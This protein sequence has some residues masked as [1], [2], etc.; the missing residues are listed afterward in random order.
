MSDSKI[1]IRRYEPGLKKTWDDFV[2]SSKNGTFLFNRDYMDY[3]SHRF[4]DFSLIVYFKNKP[5]CLLPACIK[6]DTLFSHAGLT[7]GGLVM[8]S[9]C[10]SEVILK[11]FYE[12]QRFLTDC[13]IQKVIYKPVPYIYHSLPAQEDLYALF[14]LEA[15]LIGRNVS[16]TYDR[17]MP[18]PP[19]RLRRRSLV[20]AH[21]FGV[22]IEESN[23]LDTFWQ[24]METNLSQKYGASPVHSLEEMKLLKRRFPDNIKFF[25]ASIGQ[26]MVAGG[27]F[28]VSSEVIHAQYIHANDEGKA[29][30][31]NDALVNHIINNE[32]TDKRY[33][34]FGTSNEDMGKVLNE[35]LIH[36]KESFGGRAVCYDI[37]E[38]NLKR[39][40]LGF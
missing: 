5:Y 22:K 10:V 6:E 9:S 33:F 12:I 23:D 15:R 28:Y 30:G 2:E 14:R 35:S 19:S 37:Y 17:L 36:Q 26:R 13:H 38:I 40:N 18:I 20:K 29:M 31:A 3:H 11:V 21:D 4:K 34:D 39:D 32:F 25:S 24:I 8:N 27:I 16:C 1:E 7:Y